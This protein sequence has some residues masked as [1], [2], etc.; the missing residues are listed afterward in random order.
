[1][2]LDTGSYYRRDRHL[3][4]VQLCNWVCLTCSDTFFK[5]FL[6][7]YTYNITFKSYLVHNILFE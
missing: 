2:V 4:G 3:V 6:Y 7:L 5:H 1:M